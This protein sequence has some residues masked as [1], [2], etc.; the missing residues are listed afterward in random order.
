MN[1][2]NKPKSLCWDCAKACGGCAWS[3]HWK[4]QPIDGWTAI[5]NDLKSKEGE[6]I[7]SYIVT[8]CP[9]FERDAEG[10]GQ[11]RRRDTVERCV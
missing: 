7:E 10:Y 11:V 9:E 5:R 4:H 1:E 6:T 8:G 3:D 2:F